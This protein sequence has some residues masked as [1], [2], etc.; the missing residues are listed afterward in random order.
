MGIKG[1]V[2]LDDPISEMNELPHDGDGDLEWRKAIASQTLSKGFEGLGLSAYQLPP[3]RI[4][5][6]G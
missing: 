5:E 1:C 4:S 3:F 2:V 6:G